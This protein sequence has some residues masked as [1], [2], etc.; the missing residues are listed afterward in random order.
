MIIKDIK[1]FS[2]NIWKNN[3]IAKTILETWFFFNVIFI[4]ELSWTTICSILSSRSIEGKELVGVYN[5]PNWLIFARN[6]SSNNNSLRVVT[7]INIRLLSFWFLLHRDLLNHR[8]ISLISFFNNSIIFFLINMYSDSFQST[9]KYLK[10]IEANIHNVLVI[11]GNFNIRDSYEILSV[12]IICLVAIF[13]L[14]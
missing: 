4:Q 11:T 5:H 12:L 14:K 10:N 9:L 6:L 13:L 1:I 7:Y 3:L 2:Q 8:N